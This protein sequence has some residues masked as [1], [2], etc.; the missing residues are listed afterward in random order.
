MTPSSMHN[1][2]IVTSLCLCGDICTICFPFV[3]YVAID[4]PTSW[5]AHSSSFAYELFLSV[6]SSTC[7]YSSHSYVG[8]ATG[9]CISLAYTLGSYD[10]IHSSSS[11]FIYYV[12]P[13]SSWSVGFCSK[14]GF[15]ISV[16]ELMS[17]PY[18]PRICCSF[19]STIIRLTGLITGEGMESTYT[20]YFC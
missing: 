17:I 2:V 4:G 19:S 15:F 7:T 9:C 6:T 18:V 16:C 8:S 11:S 3:I 1:S 10:S 5:C 20:T 14:L 13:R 12:S